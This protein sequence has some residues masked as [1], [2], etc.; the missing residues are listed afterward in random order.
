MSEIV[1]QRDSK[2]SQLFFAPCFL[3]RAAEERPSLACLN[4]V[5][6]AFAVG[7]CELSDW[8]NLV[9]RTCSSEIKHFLMALGMECTY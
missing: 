5:Q 8:S 2:D 6:L 1:V 4:V 7:V 9:K 3:L